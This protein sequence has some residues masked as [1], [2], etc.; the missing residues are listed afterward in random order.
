MNNTIITSE[1]IAAVDRSNHPGII[2]AYLRKLG[3]W[4]EAY[5]RLHTRCNTRPNNNTRPEGGE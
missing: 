1:L 4:R 3:V 2:Y 5:L